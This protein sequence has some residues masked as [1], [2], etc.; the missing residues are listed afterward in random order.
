MC[1]SYILMSVWLA[2]LAW[3]TYAYTQVYCSNCDTCLQTKHSEPKGEL[4]PRQKRIE[5]PTREKA[6]STTGYYIRY[7]NNGIINWYRHI[8]LIV[9]ICSEQCENSGQEETEYQNHC[10]QMRVSK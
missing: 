5:A 3:Q 8:M 1:S 7:S 2:W 6:L 10:L 9:E 4:K